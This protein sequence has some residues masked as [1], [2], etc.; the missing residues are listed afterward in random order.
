VKKDEVA[1][2][3]RGGGGGRNWL[4]RGE[5]GEKKETRGGGG[6]ENTG[7]REV[8]VKG[9]GGSQGQGGAVR[10]SCAKGWEGEIEN[11]KRTSKWGGSRRGR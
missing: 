10:G 11:A 5:E 9:V 3:R 8:K 6:G 1:G 2:R 7:H 4:R